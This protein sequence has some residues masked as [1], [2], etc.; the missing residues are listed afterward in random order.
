MF[1]STNRDPRI[2]VPVSMYHNR[3]YLLAHQR[4]ED[5]TNKGLI[6][7]PLFNH[8]FDTIIPRSCEY[9]QWLL[10]TQITYAPTKKSACKDTNAAI[11]SK[12]HMIH[13]YALV[14]VLHIKPASSTKKSITYRITEKTNVVCGISSSSASSSN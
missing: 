12:L 2:L 13:A 9:T 8:T 6:D 10:C 11:P 3:I 5:N 7:M 4:K 14:T 1:S